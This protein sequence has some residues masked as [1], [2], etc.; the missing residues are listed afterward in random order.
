MNE[1][2]KQCLIAIA[3]IGACYASIYLFYY[4]SKYLGYI[5]QHIKMDNDSPTIAV[6]I[7]LINVLILI[8]Y[9]IFI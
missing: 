4:A 6:T 2:L 5:N 3:F 9:Y 1:D 8:A 7:Y